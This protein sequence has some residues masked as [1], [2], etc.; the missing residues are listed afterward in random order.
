MN[1][2]KSKDYLSVGEASKLCGI[3][4]K[5]IRKLCDQEKI[6]YY[7][8]LSG[9]RKISRLSISKM[10]G[11]IS[12]IEE[13]SKVQKIN[14]IYSR[15]STQK[16]HD[17]LS[18]QVDYIKSRNSKYAAYTSLQ[19]IGSG[20]NFKRKGLRKILESCLQGN[21]GEVVIA[22]RDRLCRFAF[23]LIKIIIEGAGGFITVINDENH[24]S[25]E[26]ELSEDLLSIIQIY[27]CKSMGK[28][29]YAKGNKDKIE[30]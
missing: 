22:Y 6:E 8:T 4:P 9:H 19:D 28:R 29:R 13:I 5:T 30:A 25:S 12:P 3:C 21:I 24:K 23:E 16:Q 17:D 1:D 26:Q 27:C 2:E 20:I 14:Y 18:R 10:C 11:I 15:V 7:K